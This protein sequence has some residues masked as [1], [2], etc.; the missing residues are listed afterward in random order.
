M[1]QLALEPPLPADESP[2]PWT[3]SI[4]VL[5]GVLAIGGMGPQM[6]IWTVPCPFLFERDQPI[7][8]ASQMLFWWLAD[9][10]WF[11]Q[12][13][14]RDRA[15]PMDRLQDGDTLSMLSQ[16]AEELSPLLAFVDAASWPPDEATR[17]SASTSAF[18]LARPSM[19]AVVKPA[20]TDRA[21]LAAEDVSE[22]IGQAL[23]QPRHQDLDMGRGWMRC[24]PNSG[25]GVSVG[26]GFTDELPL[27]EIL[28][29]LSEA[30]ASLGIDLGWVR[31]GII[32]VDYPTTPPGREVC[33]RNCL[34]LSG[35]TALKSFAY[36]TRLIAVYTGGS[37]AGQRWRAAFVGFD[38]LA[39]A[40]P[41]SLTVVNEAS[42]EIQVV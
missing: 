41:P 35:S 24:M 8:A 33:D 31:A 40:S 25:W 34:D 32:C 9:R 26:F 30:L 7:P 20:P 3:F 18:P 21:W 17:R 19:V 42:P 14:G 2:A 5:K 36:G 22:M 6:R 27:P 23:A 29:H 4:E 12:Q 37:S 39:D 13:F 28:R 1:S 16:V 11:C 15:W 38:D 10:D